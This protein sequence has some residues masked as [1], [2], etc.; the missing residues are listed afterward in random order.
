MYIV[1]SYLL[2][3]IFCVIT[4]LCWGSWANTQKLVQKKWR[5]ELFYWDYVIGI[6]LFSLILAMTMG[7][8]GSEG[9]PFL[10]DLPQARLKFYR[11]GIYNILTKGGY[12]FFRQGFIFRL[13]EY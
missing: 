6:F 8:T 2:A 13:H 5:F 11:N 7:S 10:E 3:I 4:M 1:D 9:R 12:F